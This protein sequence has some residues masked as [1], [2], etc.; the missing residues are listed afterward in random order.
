MLLAT[1][2]SAVHNTGKAFLQ[3]QVDAVLKDHSFPPI[4]T[5]LMPD[6]HRKG[7]SKV[8]TIRNATKIEEQEGKRDEIEEQLLKLGK[9]YLDKFEQYEIVHEDKTINYQA[10]KTRNEDGI[11]VIMIKYRIDGFTEDHW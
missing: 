8:R 6:F 3:K 4:V 7:I 11:P 2:V 9:S 10:R 5:T 1:A